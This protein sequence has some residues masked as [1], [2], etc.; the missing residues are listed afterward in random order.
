MTTNF[1][2]EVEQEK[3]TGAK[4]LVLPRNARERTSIGR[5]V[6]RLCAAVALRARV[7]VMCVAVYVVHVFIV[8]AILIKLRVGEED[9][10]LEALVRE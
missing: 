7:A 5:A 3:P 8:V 4:D 10:R 6:T 9:E 2:E 1:E